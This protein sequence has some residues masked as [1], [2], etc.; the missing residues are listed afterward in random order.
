MAKGINQ[1]WKL[2]YYGRKRSREKYDY[3]ILS[4]AF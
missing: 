1:V 3:Q 2:F 4:V